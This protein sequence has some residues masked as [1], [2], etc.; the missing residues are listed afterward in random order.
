MANINLELSVFARPIKSEPSKLLLTVC[1]I[2][3]TYGAT[4][5]IRNT[6]SLFQTGFQVQTIEGHIHPYT[7]AS[8]TNPSEEEQSLD[9]LYSNQPVFA[10]GHGCS[11]DWGEPRSDNPF[12]RKLAEGAKTVNKIFATPFPCYELSNISAE[13]KSGDKV[14]TA[15]MKALGG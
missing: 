13:I 1:F 7:E 8:L 10:S 15:S 11:A 12:V 2:N 4:L 5:E 14:L 3:R 9:L 6:C